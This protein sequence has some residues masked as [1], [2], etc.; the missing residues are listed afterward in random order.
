MATAAHKSRMIERRERQLA[1]VPGFTPVQN[2]RVQGAI[3]SAFVIIQASKPHLTTAE[4]Q[5]E[6]RRFVAKN[7]PRPSRSK[8]YRPR[9]SKSDSA[10]Y[11]K[12]AV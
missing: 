10:K 9:P 3:S 4:A 2:G 6:A 12:Q 7:L 11:R 1:R 8:L 5:D